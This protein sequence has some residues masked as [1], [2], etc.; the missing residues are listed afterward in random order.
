M[1]SRSECFADSKK[2]IYS[3]AQVRRNVGCDR[4][5]ASLGGSGNPAHEGH[6]CLVRPS[7]VIKAIDVHL[8]GAS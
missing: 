6:S 8:L 7:L 5:I 3:S 2:K 1:T 4:K